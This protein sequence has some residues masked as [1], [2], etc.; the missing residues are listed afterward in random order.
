MEEEGGGKGEVGGEESH[1]VLSK[2]TILSWSAFI[3]I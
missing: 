1:N 3:A 2:F